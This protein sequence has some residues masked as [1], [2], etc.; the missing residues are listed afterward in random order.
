MR[1]GRNAISFIGFFARRGTRHLLISVF[2]VLLLGLLIGTVARAGFVDDWITQKA[3]TSPGYFEGQKR[4]YFTGGSFSAR[5][6]QTR[7]YL[8]SF[9]PPRLKFGCGGIDAFMGGFSFMNFEYLVQKLQRILQAAPAAAFDLAL[10]NL[11][12]PCSNVIK[13]MEAISDSLNSL[14][15][16]D[17]KASTVLAAKLMD[18]FTDN[19]KIHAEARK[20]YALG[21]GIQDLPQKLTD[22][23]KSNDNKDDQPASELT[24]ECPQPIKD[25]FATP[26]STLLQ[27]I[28]EKR[29]YPASHA[30]LVRGLV[31]DVMV[32]DFGGDQQ[33]FA[34]VPPC[35]ENKP[36]DTYSFFSGSLY[37]RPM[38]G[39]DYGACV[40][41]TDTNAN[42]QQWAVDKLG[43]IY[44]KMQNKTALTTDEQA[45]IDAVPLPVGI[46]L[47]V[48]MTTKQ[49]NQMMASLAMIMARAYAYGMMSDLYGEVIQGIYTA[50]ALVSKQGQSPKPGCSIDLLSGGIAAMEDL[51]KRT[52]AF[53]T[54]VK[55]DYA[56]SLHEHTAVMDVARRYEEFRKLSE[57]KL[58]KAFSPGLAGRVVGGL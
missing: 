21:K 43:S 36:D 15:L 2:A 39:N 25:T 52:L 57:D 37:T 54:N 58:S 10:K 28:F 18:P 34:F 33:G 48:A 13:S 56:N 41:A 23:W 24:S 31:G 4:G 55:Q 22:I 11:C 1:N 47:K 6:P 51:A 19:S 29:G 50:R 9:E 3:E 7:D 35:T 5:W 16:D 45:F 12:E 17:C 30:D 38:N 49:G 46:S 27:K 20:E 26:G 44:Q 40:V 32:A 8:M 42:L 53:A 14:Q